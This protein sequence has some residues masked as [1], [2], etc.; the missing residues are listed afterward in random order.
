MPPVEKIM[1]RKRR[2]ELEEEE[3]DVEEEGSSVREVLL[4]KCKELWAVPHTK[5]QEQLLAGY[6]DLKTHRFAFSQPY[7]YRGPEMY[8][9]RRFSRRKASILAI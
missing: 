3:V 5:E 6:Y 9:M 1:T 2:R 7:C 4:E 8:D